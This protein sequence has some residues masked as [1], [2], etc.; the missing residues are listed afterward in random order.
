MPAFGMA[1]KALWK[2]LAEVYEFEP[3][4]LQLLTMACRQADDLSRLETAIR[5]DGVHLVGSMGQKVLNPALA[6]ARLARAAIGRLLGELDLPSFTEE[7][8]PRTAASRHGKKAAD[9]RWLRVAE[10]RDG[11]S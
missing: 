2:R 5:R 3:R 9:S 8:K 11:P 10:G 4:E 1:G 7:A 6:E